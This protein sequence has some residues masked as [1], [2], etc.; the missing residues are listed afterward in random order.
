MEFIAQ[1]MVEENANGQV[2]LK[3]GERKRGTVSSSAEEAK[4]KVFEIEI[5]EEIGYPCAVEPIQRV[6]SERSIV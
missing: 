1:G 4:P 2:R 6:L 3:E 5:E